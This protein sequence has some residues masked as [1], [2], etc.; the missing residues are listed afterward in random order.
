MI[1]LRPVTMKRTAVYFEMTFLADD[2]DIYYTLRSVLTLDPGLCGKVPCR[3]FSGRVAA[4]L[5]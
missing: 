3:L 5:V 1:P 2:N 4:V